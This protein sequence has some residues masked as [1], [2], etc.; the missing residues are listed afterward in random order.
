[1]EEQCGCRKGRSC[2]DDIFSLRGLCELTGKAG[3]DVHTCF[4][5]LITD[6]YKGTTCA[7]QTD[8]D[9]ADSW[10]QVLTGL[11][12]GDMNAPLFLMSFWIASASILNPALVL[13]AFTWPIT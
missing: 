6:P 2:N 7:M 12:Q 5:D 11:K 13:W 9:K 3:R 8:K 4:I 10:C 1:M